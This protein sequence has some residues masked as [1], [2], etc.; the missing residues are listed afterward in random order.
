MP[1]L[2][3][4]IVPQS[5]ANADVVER[6]EGRSGIE[7]AVDD[8]PAPA[9]L[10]GQEDR[11]G[12]IEGGAV[13]RPARAPARTDAQRQEIMARLR[14]APPG[15]GVAAAQAML[16]S[17][18][19]EPNPLPPPG[20]ARLD[21]ILGQLTS[22][23]SGPS[24]EAGPR[25]DQA[26]LDETFDEDDRPVDARRP[27]QLMCPTCKA[28]HFPVGG[29]ERISMPVRDAEKGGD[30]GTGGENRGAAQGEGNERAVLT[31]RDLGLDS[32]EDESVP[33][34]RAVRDRGGDN[35]G[36]P[37]NSEG[38]SP[39]LEFLELDVLSKM[40]TPQRT[41]RTPEQ[42]FETETVALPPVEEGGGG[43]PTGE[44]EDGSQTRPVRPQLPPEIERI[45]VDMAKIT[46][47][48][49]HLRDYGALRAYTNASCP[50]C[51][52]ECEP[53]IVLP[54]GH[55]LCEEDFRRMGG[56]LASDKE[57]LKALVEPSTSQ[58][59][60]AAATAR[61]SNA[62]TQPSSRRGSDGIPSSVNVPSSAMP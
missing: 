48:L 62:R 39:A 7:D 11:A 61:R 27:D 26:L 59:W 43:R 49:T 57:R 40:S 41:G 34:Y 10:S 17:I 3:Q 32:S 50:V 56:Y 12:I 51:L 60:R 9:N 4:I 16:A 15:A 54:C 35:S 24:G 23:L 46:S 36:A 55:C 58:E 53:T 1:R 8:D 33:L 44:S 45:T 14:R 20:P 25:Q 13:D 30:G 18:V 52:E 47:P 38:R 2:Q 5:D 31:T 37:G 19:P 28:V 21:A 42:I 29:S 6:Q 22:H